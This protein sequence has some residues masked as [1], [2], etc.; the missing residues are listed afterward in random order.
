MSAMF[1]FINGLMG[2]KSRTI[3]ALDFDL[4]WNEV[5]IGDKWVPVDISALK[6]SRAWPNPV[7]KSKFNWVLVFDDGKVIDVIYTF[8]WINTRT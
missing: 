8:I 6:E 7:V 1:A 4:M 3:G 2:L 5:R